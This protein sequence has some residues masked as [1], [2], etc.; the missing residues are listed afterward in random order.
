[1]ILLYA[2]GNDV[3]FPLTKRPDYLGT[4]GGQISLPGGKAEAGETLIETALRET[5]EEIGI[6][7]E[8]IEVLGTLSDFFVIPSNFMVTPVVGILHDEPVFTPDPK[9]VVRVFKGSVNQTIRKRSHSHQRDSGRQIIS[10]ART[11]L[12]NRARSSV[13]RYRHDSERIQN[14]PK[15]AEL[16]A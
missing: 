8:S 4:H 12:R 6:K 2:A 9:E 7:P 3:L 11:T 15:R 10:H 13:G 1:M 14:N 5:E 16:N